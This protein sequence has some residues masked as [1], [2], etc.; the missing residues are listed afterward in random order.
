[1]PPVGGPPLTRS[2]TRFIQPWRGG[3]SLRCVGATST[4]SEVRCLQRP[5]QW[6]VDVGDLR[7]I[8]T[9]LDPGGETTAGEQYRASLALGVRETAV[10]NDLA[11]F[12][13]TG[14]VAG[15]EDPV[16]LAQEPSRVLAL[17][18]CPCGG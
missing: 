15:N 18:V 16:A 8:V 2:A 9:E 14:A 6:E 17:G 4:V 13:A 10:L 5:T 11:W 1:M 12:L 3:I 7:F